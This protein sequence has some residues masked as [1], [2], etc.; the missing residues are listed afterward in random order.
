MSILVPFV[1]WLEPLLASGVMQPGDHICYCPD[2]DLHLFPL[3]Y[4]R[5][6]N[7][8]LIDT[9][10]LSRTQGVASIL[11]MLAKPT[12]QVSQ[13]LVVQATA[14]QDDRDQKKKAAFGE[15]GNWL[16]TQM[17]GQILIDEQADFEYIT[18]QSASG[19]LIHF[20]THGYF[21]YKTM[22]E[23]GGSP[24]YDS[25]LL[26]YA[27]G[28]RPVN[29]PEDAPTKSQVRA[30]THKEEEEK[31]NKKLK[32]WQRR[33]PFLLSPD[34]LLRAGWNIDGSHVTLQGCVSGQAKEGIG[35]DAL[36]LDW[37]LLQSG[38]NSLLSTG[39]NVDV[40]W[41]NDFCRLFYQSWQQ[42]HSKAEAHRQACLLLKAK[43][44]AETVPDDLI[45]P[46]YW[47][48]FSLTGDWR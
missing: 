45:S 46:Y 4:I 30:E 16:T 37:A 10:S 43:R 9:F 18:K 20:S 47:A 3:Q 22:G 27:D 42:G 28:Q 39:W 48:A 13:F 2:G 34:R 36:G 33:N 26:V 7:N 32:N 1:N 17:T 25:G 31:E 38:A 24:Y 11:D 14:E 8:Y 23:E 19:R 12:R 40:Y 5:F 41:A 44:K 15:I 35:G 6:Q 21:P 29:L